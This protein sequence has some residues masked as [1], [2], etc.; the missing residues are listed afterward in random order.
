MCGSSSNIA[1]PCF[2]INTVV[3]KTLSEIADALGKANDIPSATLGIIKDLLSAHQRVIF[4]GNNYAEEWVTEAETRGLPN[5]G[6]T[7]LSIK[8]LLKDKNKDV[9][10]SMG[11][12]TEKEIESRYEILLENYLKTVRIEALTLADITDRQ[13]LPATLTYA[14]KLSDAAE[15]TGSAGRQEPSENDRFPGRRNGRPAHQAQGRALLRT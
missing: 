9:F 6:N 2:T 7:V 13:L 11:V 15:K 5:I 3:A 12:L 1:E 4:N 14:L 10:K 8:E